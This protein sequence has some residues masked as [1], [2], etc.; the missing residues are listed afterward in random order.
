VVEPPKPDL[1]PLKARL[2]ALE[3][4]RSRRGILLADVPR[5]RLALLEASRSLQAEDQAR[6]KAAVG[7]LKGILARTKIDKAFIAKKLGRL[8]RLRGSKKL[9]P[10][11]AQRLSRAFQK[12]HAS[13]FAGKYEEAN[14]HLNRIW[15]I[16]RP[17]D[18]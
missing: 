9:D 8:N 12:V 5:Y 18:S 14:S 10:K 6:M 7:Q 17:S 1:G 2:K 11:T 3:R 15:R 16:L 13:Y 4:D